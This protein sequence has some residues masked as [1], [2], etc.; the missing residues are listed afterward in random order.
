MIIAHCGETWGYGGTW[1]WIIPLSLS[2]LWKPTVEYPK[3]SLP[4]GRLGGDS[5]LLHSALM[6]P[7]HIYV[8]PNGQK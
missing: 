5:C 6:E 7:L 8:V 1:R 3:T 4:R 2:V